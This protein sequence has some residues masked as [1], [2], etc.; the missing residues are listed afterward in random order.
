MRAAAALMEAAAPTARQRRLPV[1]V[2]LLARASSLRQWGLS[3][4]T[5]TGGA[6]AASVSAHS[7]SATAGWAGLGCGAGVKSRAERQSS[8][9]NAWRTGWRR[10]GRGWRQLGPAGGSCLGDSHSGVAA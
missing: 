6:A 5:L 7:P 8:V 10:R 3:A 2:P 1:L 9:E 4:F